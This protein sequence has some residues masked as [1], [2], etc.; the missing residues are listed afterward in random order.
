MNDER[1]VVAT[2][3]KYRD[4]LA[5][6]LLIGGFTRKNRETEGLIDP[7]DVTQRDKIKFQLF[8]RAFSLLSG[9]ITQAMTQ[10]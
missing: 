2:R 3:H 9:E 7:I 6:I 4:K 1:S 5:V 10:F 8:R